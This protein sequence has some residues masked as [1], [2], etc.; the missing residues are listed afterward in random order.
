LV[1][2]Q[3]EEPQQRA[4]FSKRSSSFLLMLMFFVYIL[5][6]KDFDKYYIGHT[7][8][9]ENRLWSHN[10]SERVTYTSKYRPWEVVACFEAGT[11]RGGA[12]KIERKLKKLKSKEMYRRI[13]AGQLPD[14]LAQLVRVPNE[15]RD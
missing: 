1:Q 10:N 9:M 15:I 6:S 2:V 3:E 14:F 11:E 8:N 13:I 12:M 5:F 7:D 4:V